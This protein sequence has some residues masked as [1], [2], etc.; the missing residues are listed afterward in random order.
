MP[1]LREYRQRRDPGRTPEPF[2]EGVEA[3]AG[4][5]VGEARRFVVQQHAARSLHYDF[6]L[7]IDGVLTSWAVPRGPSLEPADR[8]LAV[9]TEDH[10]LEYAQ[11]EGVI[12]A[13][14]YGAGAV[15]VWD[16]GRYWT[17]DGSSPAQGLAAGKL[18]LALEGYKLAG[19]FA[20][21]RTRGEQSRQW[22]L[23]CKQAHG[24]QGRQHDLR[25]LIE[26]APRS[27]LSGLTVAEMQAGETRGEVVRVLL[28]AAG[29][30]ALAQPPDDL[31]PM[32]AC[33]ERE[34]FS[35]PGWLFEP[36]YDGVR[37]L[38]FKRAQR[39]EL[40]A[41]SGRD[42]SQIYPELVRAAVRLPLADFVLDGE[43]VARDAHGRSSFGRLQQR[44]ALRD[45]LQIARAELAVPVELCA[46]DLLW[47][48]GRDLRPL[49]L[50]VRKRVLRCLAPEL[51]VVRYTDHIEEA[52]CELY[53]LAQRHGFEGIVAKLADSPYEPGVRTRNWLKIKVPRSAWLRVVGYLPGRGARAALGALLLAWQREGRWVY[54]GRV[55]SGLDAA[56]VE[57]FC[58]RHAAPAD[59]P[60][61]CVPVE[62]SRRARGVRG[63][64]AAEVRYAGVTADGLLRLPILLGLS[65]EQPL[66]QC[67]A[68]QPEPPP[69]ALLAAAPAAAAP[70]PDPGA[71]AITRREKVFWPQQ[72]YTKGDLLDYYE[73]VWPWLARYLHDRPLVVT[74]YP[75][76]IAGGSFFQKNAP[77][78]TPQWATRRTLDG[79][80]YFICNELRTLLHVVNSGAIPLHV[81]NSR[82]ASVERPDWLVLDL[83]PN[84]APLRDAIAVARRLRQ[85]LAELGCPSFAK[86]SG[87]DGLHVMV[88]LGAQLAHDEAKALGE[89]LARAVCAELSDIATIVRPLAA[90]GGRVY[91]D[92]LQ[93]GRGKLIAA[94]LAARARPGATV[95]MPLRWGQVSAR[96]DPGRYTIRS[97]PA[98]LA[99]SGDP[100]APLLE[101]SVDVP[102]LLD[103]L[104]ARLDRHP[105]PSSAQ[106]S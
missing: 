101:Q 88:P 85:M 54:A 65:A 2:G 93:N 80:D 12:P 61:A 44:L 55:G 92:F 45:P 57:E 64:L 72:G 75:D 33:E 82:L 79:I 15:I 3:V 47:A 76:G 59:P 29:A 8:R 38:L 9:R 95:S 19:N 66:E 56:L 49:P 102:A 67:T 34:A 39:A 90:R 7:E 91:V 74:R 28:D 99:R 17:R 18:D 53:G 23:I 1:D 36:K 27:V 48:D 84:E 21:V 94:P 32:L 46:F 104:V 62:L 41:R 10:P 26:R 25:P 96:L 14:N 5:T 86:T 100:M 22:L 11:F 37:V 98:L 40:R 63:P 87:Q 70:A 78:W 60:D 43:L 103:A 4:R 69:P 35:R 58:A 42:V 77:E 51:G 73:A 52:G 13:E 97:A 105:G 16:A 71:P 83:D 24:G 68:A 6:R 31:R 50:R 89:V 20:L 81:W 30:P 106:D